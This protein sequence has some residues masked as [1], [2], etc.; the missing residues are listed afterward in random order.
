VR[1]EY[2]S[3]DNAA[4]IAGM[5]AMAGEILRNLRPDYLTVVNEPDTTGVNLH[6]QIEPALYRE[7]IAGILAGQERG[8]TLIGAGAGT[9]SP[10]EYF[11]IAARTPGLDYIDLHIYPINRD[12]A[13]GKI[14]QIAALAKTGG[15]KLACG[16]SWL[17]KALAEE[18]GGPSVINFPRVVGRDV[19]SFWRP[20]DIRFHEGMLRTGA[21][22]D[23]Q[24]VSFFWMRYYFGNVD[25]NTDYARYTPAML[26]SRANEAAGAN[27]YTRHFSAL[28]EWLRGVLTQ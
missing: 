14:E 17:Y 26:I 11:E 3:Q 22:Y 20:F 13:T 24:F 25:Y 28:G 7:L 5:H 1:F 6:R 12:W 9:W 27:I 23:L 4:V 18:L 10:L 16:E 8:A 21:K 15:K 2:G 19:F